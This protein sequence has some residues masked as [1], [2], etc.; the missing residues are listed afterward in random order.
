MYTAAKCFLQGRA[1]GEAAAEACLRRLASLEGARQQKET[2][3]GGGGGGGKEDDEGEA[4]ALRRALA[5]AYLRWGQAC[6]AEAKH[7]D[8]CCR[9]AFKA[10]SKGQGNTGCRRSAAEA[11][12][13]AVSASVAAG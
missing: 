10:F 8:R 12:A 13:A 5:R 7:E 1:D 9:S 4:P 2:V 11:A 3:G 6:L